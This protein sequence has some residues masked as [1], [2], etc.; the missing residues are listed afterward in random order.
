MARSG[1]LHNL[2]SHLLLAFFGLC[3]R[4]TA[5]FDL[6]TDDLE[7]INEIPLTFHSHQDAERKR[8][9]GLFMEEKLADFSRKKVADFL[10][11]LGG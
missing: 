6:D 4:T 5:A 9:G 2:S 11:L 7:E 8:N 10:T 3:S 1:N